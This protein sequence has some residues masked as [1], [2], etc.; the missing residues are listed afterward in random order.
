MKFTP[1]QLAVFAGAGWTPDQIKEM[2][3]YDTEVQAKLDKGEN[4]T[5]EDGTNHIETP[6]VEEPPKETPT[7]MLEKL[8]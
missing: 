4:V 7:Q 2:L 6:K 5:P 1:E 8:L 3:D